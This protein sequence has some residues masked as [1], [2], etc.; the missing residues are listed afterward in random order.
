MRTSFIVFE[1]LFICCSLQ[2]VHTEAQTTSPDILWQ[3]AYGGSSAE[4][5]RSMALTNDGGYIALGYT[6]SLDGDVISTHGVAD[7]WIVKCD[8][9]G[10]I[11]WQRTY[12]GSST[13]WGRSINTT[14]DGGYIVAG[15]SRSNNGDVIGNHGDF[16]YWILKLNSSGDITWQKSLGGSGFDNAYDAIETSDGKFVVAGFTQS[17]DGD[18]SGNH[19]QQDFLI[20]KL[21]QNGN[22]IWTKVFGGAL[23]EQAACVIETNDHAY[24]IAG[25]SDSNDGNVPDNKGKNDFWIVKLSQSGNVLWKKSYGGTKDDAARWIE[26]TPDNGFMITGYA[27]SSNKD[28]SSNHGL[29]DYWVIR[30]DSAGTLLWQKN[31]GGLLDDYPYYI[32]R[33]SDGNYVI[34]GSA[35][36][37]D[38]DVTNQY[39]TGDIWVVKIDSIGNLLSQKSYGG[40]EKDEARVILQTRNENFL[41]AGFSASPDGDV[42]SPHGGME[43]WIV[44]TCTPPPATITN[45]PIVTACKGDNVTLTAN[46]GAGYFYQW[47]KNGTAISGATN[48]YYQYTIN[49]TAGFTVT[50]TA[51]CSA[52]S[53]TT[54]VNRLNKPMGIITPLGDLNICLLGQVTL[55]VDSNP[56]SS[57]KWF[58]NDV[59][60]MNAASYV[61]TATS[62][63]DYTVKV[64]NA[65]GCSKTSDPATVYSSC[66]MAEGN[67]AMSVTVSPNPSIGN[68][69]LHIF[70]DDGNENAEAA[71]IDLIGNVVMKKSVAL[72]EGETTSAFEIPSEVANGIYFLR[73]KSD[74]DIHLIKVMIER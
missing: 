18:G 57:Y 59:R 9:T 23:D 7:Y 39:G 58:K 31:Y 72:T 21:D 66:K 70:S 33:C 12:G 67:I 29:Y 27:S 55:L 51:G 71:L 73:V 54:T 48:S 6:Q 45:G 56:K 49:N 30:I 24:L 63:G 2:C 5:F 32:K 60:I 3:H 15:Y 17:I 13:D 10:N 28:V 34:C 37:N 74:E 44:K 52:T 43:G 19:G 14:A 46:T 69:V 61:Y 64:T 20:V 25:Y 50:V 62:T 53:P 36:S 1:I 40:S 38:G 8:S 65:N 68:F 41:I 35:E 4:Q 42:T 47:N 22:K 26:K 16:D 11:E